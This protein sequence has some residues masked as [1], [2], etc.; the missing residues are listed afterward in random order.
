VWPPGPEGTEPGMTSIGRSLAHG[1]IAGAVGTTAL[2]AATYA[3]MAVRGRPASST[4]ERTVERSAELLG[5]AIP[6]DEQQ[7]KGREAGLGPLLGTA[8]GVGA[9]LLLGALRGSGWPRG[10]IATFGVASILAMV[11]GNG[12]MT[13]LGITDPRTWSVTDWVADI[14]PH[15][16]YAVAATATLSTLDRR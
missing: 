15:V 13:V 12:P 7:R 11:A 8:A 2:N 3:D 6:G 1:A 16:A 14:V 10:G 9:G 5:L 4:P